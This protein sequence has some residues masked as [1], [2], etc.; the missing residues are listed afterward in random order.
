MMMFSSKLA[1]RILCI[2]DD[3]AESK[4][5][6]AVLESFGYHVISAS[7]KIAENILLR[8]KFHLVIVSESGNADFNKVASVLRGA[9]LLILEQVVAPEHLL[10]MVADRVRYLQ[11]A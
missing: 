2:S 4:S 3:T 5:R 9:E 6:S 8:S 10:G 1:P 7:L 11:R